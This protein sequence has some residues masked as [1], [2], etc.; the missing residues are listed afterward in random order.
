M[1]RDFLGYQG[2]IS[3]LHTHKKGANIFKEEVEGGEAQVK[4]TK[5]GKKKN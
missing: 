5:I 2:E 1:E 4:F 3:Q